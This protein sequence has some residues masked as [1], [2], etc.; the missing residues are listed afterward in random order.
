[1]GRGMIFSCEYNNRTNLLILAY[2]IFLLRFVGWG[3]KG[4]RSSD[5]ILEEILTLKEDQQL[6]QASI[7]TRKD[8]TSD[9]W[10]AEGIVDEFINIGDVGCS[11]DGDDC[12]KMM[13]MMA[14]I[15]VM[16]GTTRN[17]QTILKMQ[18]AW[19]VPVKIL[20][21]LVHRITIK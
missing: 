10:E 17:K 13:L 20:A 14:V 18:I 11:D 1:M 9:M 4:G 5:E 16:M 8:Q 7:T 21:L 3:G 15:M 6:F 19:N 2:T 12:N